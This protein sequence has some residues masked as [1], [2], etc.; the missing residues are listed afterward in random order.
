[1]I[2][3]D[4]ELLKPDTILATFGKSF[5]WAWQ[6]LG[7]RLGS[8]TAMLYRFCRL[9]D[10]MADGDI[11][12][13]PSRLRQIRDDMACGSGSKDPLFVDFQDFMITK[14]LPLPVILAL[15]DGLLSDLELVDVKDEIELLRYCYN[16]AGTVGLLMSCVLGCDTE[17]A[18]AH[19][20]DLGI[21]MQL[22][23]IARDVLEDA[24]MG[25]RYLPAS[26][27]GNISPEEIV[28]IAN[29]P[30]NETKESVNRG[31]EKLL[32]L[33]E[34]YYRSGLDG[35]S[36]LPVRAHLAIS[37]AARV[38]RQIGVKIASNRFVWHEGRQFT[39]VSEK[40]ICSILALLAM[41]RR[42]L[43]VP[44]HYTYLHE[45]LKG[46]PYVE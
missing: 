23:N 11:D 25:R 43:P 33:A 7:K 41:P 29:A 3:S 4:R 38:Y 12:D 31:V 8:E 19:A 20:I 32:N 16:V 5:Y 13:G 28:K 40:T 1:M 14:K 21:A 37:V 9:L 39:S 10:D 30:M 44:H 18:R 27:V 46:L 6:F 24:Q 15:I 2:S 26:W 45:P 42:V 22:T 36:F 34:Q 17:R 35:C